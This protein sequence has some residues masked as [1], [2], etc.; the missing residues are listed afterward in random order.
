MSIHSGLCGSVVEIYKILL[1][2]VDLSFL[3][4]VTTDI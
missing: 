3:L 2:R 4:D 1:L